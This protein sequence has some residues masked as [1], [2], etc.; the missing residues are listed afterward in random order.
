MEGA[1]RRAATWN[2]SE[3]QARKILNEIREPS[4]DSAVRLNLSQNIRLTGCARRKSQS[5]TGFVRY[6][7]FVIGFVE[8][9]GKQ[10]TMHQVARVSI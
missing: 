4:S 9:V 1:A 2:L 5:M 8:H 6:K 10:R 7:D 3:E